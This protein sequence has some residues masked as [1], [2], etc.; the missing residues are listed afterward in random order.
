MD[1]EKSFKK[2]RPP[3]PHAHP[4]CFP[5]MTLFPTAA[6]CLPDGQQGYPLNSPFHHFLRTLTVFLVPV[7][8]V[9]S[10]RDESGFP[11]KKQISLF[12]CCLTPDWEQDHVA[13]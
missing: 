4:P 1:S 3:S 9:L 8:S 13:L 5:C 11:C 7:T 12:L 2:S 10:P 6:V